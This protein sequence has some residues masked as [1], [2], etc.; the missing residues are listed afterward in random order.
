MCPL[1]GERD[2]APALAIVRRDFTALLA[3]RARPAHSRRLARVRANRILE[4]YNDQPSTL[5]MGRCR[6][7]D[8]IVAGCRRPV[9]SFAIGNLVELAQLFAIGMF[10]Q[11]F[12]PFKFQL[13]PRFSTGLKK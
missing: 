5:T 12:V 7:D 8:A 3:S 10:R 9:K 1:H 4:Y 6:H 2:V 13:T 11:M